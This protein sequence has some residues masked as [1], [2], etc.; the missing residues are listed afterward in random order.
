VVGVIPRGLN[1]ETFN[2]FAR[3]RARLVLF[4]LP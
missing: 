4:E 3:S 2:P 1:L